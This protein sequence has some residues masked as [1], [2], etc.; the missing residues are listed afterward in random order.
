MTLF[1][2][3]AVLMVL[4]GLY[5]ILPPL[6]GRYK[7]SETLHNELNLAIYQQRLAELEEDSDTDL[8]PEQKEQARK[9]L[10]KSLLQDIDTAETSRSETVP[11]KQKSPTL[12]VAIGFM[13]PLLA[14]GFYGLLGPAELP[15][16]LAGKTGNGARHV[17]TRNQGDAVDVNEMVRKLEARLQQ[18]P[19]D[20]EGW[21]LLAR[22]YMYMQRFGEAAEAYERAIKLNGDDPRLLTDYAEALAMKRGGN[23]QGKPEE[24]VLK[25]LRLQPMHP[26]SLWLAGAAKFQS[27][28]YQA[29]IDYWQRLLK[30]HE[31]GSE[32][33]RELQKRIDMARQALEENGG[34]VSV[35]GSEK[36]KP[37]NTTATELTVKVALDPR[38]IDHARPEDTVFIFARAANGPPMPLAVVRKQVRDLPVEVTL[39]DSMAMTPKARLSSFKKVY[40]SA[41]ISKSGTAEPQAGDLQGRSQVVATGGKLNLNLMIDQQ[42]H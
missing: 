29:A 21:P 18:N 1:I 37:K 36:A 16:I 15:E 35:S 6:L 31:D 4:A 33:A 41:R 30:M 24:L 22:S 39:D 8:S 32:G 9:E 14:L 20:A 40:V 13:V 38:F 25:A 34:A 42:V 12:A 3:L 7:V 28:Q 19:D 2:T 23:M 10:E 5:F 11:Q 26:K 17:S 27:G